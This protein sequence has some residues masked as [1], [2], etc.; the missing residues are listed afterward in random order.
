MLASAVVCLEVFAVVATIDGIYF[1]LMKY[2]LFSRPESRYEHRLHTIHAIFFP[3][4]VLLL[5]LRETSGAFL[6]ATV[7][8]VA[9]DFF[10][11]MLDVVCERASRREI[12]GLSTT[13][14]AVHVVAITSRVAAFTLALASRPATAWNIAR[15]S[16][17]TAQ[18]PALVVAT[19]WLILGGG[20]AVAVI[21]LWLLRR[22][23]VAVS[24]EG[25]SLN[26]AN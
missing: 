19:C 21:H 12:G 7:A 1:H 17:Q 22:P 15:S 18:L 14:Y 4:L 10:V 23:R 25:A 5:F 9:A 3:A 24:A 8:L 11:E 20:I 2:R 16:I 26:T 6:W 13:E